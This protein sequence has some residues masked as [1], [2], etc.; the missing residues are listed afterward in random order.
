MFTGL[1][2]HTYSPTHPLTYLH[3]TAH[4]PTCTFL[5][6]H[7]P[8]HCSCIA[9]SGVCY[10]HTSGT[11]HHTYTHRA[12]THTVH[13]HTLHLPTPHLPTIPTH[14]TTPI[15]SPYLHTRNHIH[16]HLHQNTHNPAI[17]NDRTSRMYVKYCIIM[18]NINELKRR[19]N[20]T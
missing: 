15:Y 4:T 5:Y 6:I 18:P 10:T 7:T 1:H 8:T 14:Q 2:A 16:T 12:P 17:S 13:L 19:I 11:V 9:C 20:L 3:K